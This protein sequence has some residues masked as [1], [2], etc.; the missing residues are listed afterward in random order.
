MGAI[1]GLL[2]LIVLAGGGYFAWTHLAPRAGE[3]RQIASQSAVQIGPTGAAP[4]ATQPVAE[5]PLA[6]S[7]TPPVTPPPILPITTINFRTG[8][9]MT[10]SFRR[11]QGDDWG[12]YTAKGERAFQFRQRTQTADKLELYDASRNMTIA[13]DLASKR[14]FWR[15]GAGPNNP[16]YEVVSVDR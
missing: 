13:I 3:T 4:D 10:G 7:M 16:L 2:A 8:D 15:E 6:A 14:I 1:A 11:E 12:E 5:A 9:G